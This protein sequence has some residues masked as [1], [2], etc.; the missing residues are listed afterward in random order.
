MQSCD[1]TCSHCA[2]EFWAWL[3][4]RMKSAEREAGRS[5]AGSFSAAAATS[6]RPG[7]SPW[8]VWFKT[9]E[10]EPWSMTEV[11]TVSADAAWRWFSDLAVGGY[12]TAMAFRV[13]DVQ[14]QHRPHGMS[15]PR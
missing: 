12:H 10:R 9:L 13:D 7:A 2:R 8:T 4:G 5:G 1:Q 6:I 11:A 14:P 3:K 15:S